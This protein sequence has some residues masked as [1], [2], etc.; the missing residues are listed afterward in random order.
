MI[1]LLVTVLIALLIIYVCMY[2]IGMIGLPEPINMVAKAI[3]V[4]VGILFI[5]QKSGFGNFI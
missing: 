4:I 5:L 1:T 2:L 3:I